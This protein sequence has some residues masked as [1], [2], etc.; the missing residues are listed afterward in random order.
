MLRG[1]ADKVVSFLTNAALTKT[2][3]P[4]DK[5]YNLEML[6]T[7]HQARPHPRRRPGFSA[8]R[9]SVAARCTPRRGARRHAGT[10]GAV[11]G[12]LG[13]TLR[14]RRLGRRTSRRCTTSPSSSTSAGTTRVRCC[15]WLCVHNLF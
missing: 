7:E 2:L 14:V 10:R 1:T 9:A 5:A 6:R 8:A 4:N 15:V 3:R 12:F 11:L 13:L